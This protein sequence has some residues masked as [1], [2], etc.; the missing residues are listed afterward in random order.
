MESWT[1]IARK[2]QR[3]ARNSDATRDVR[4]EKKDKIQCADT[5]QALDV[6]I[7]I[8]THKLLAASPNVHE[9]VKE[10]VT[11]KKV[12]ANTVEVNNVDTYLADGLESNP[13]ADYLKLFKYDSSTSSAAA[14][15]P[16]QVIFP[17]F[18]PGVKLECILNG[19]AQVIIM[20]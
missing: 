1:C 11:S 6:K 16:L 4:E 12:S 7:T 19:G 5:D 10:L 9:Q 18:T 20:R 14:S 15:L 8:S 3:V 17:T 13:S 2:S